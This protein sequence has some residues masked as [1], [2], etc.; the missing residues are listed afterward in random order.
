LNIND[1]K[2]SIL[3]ID[4][5]SNTNYIF[6]ITS[7]NSIKMCIYDDEMEL[8]ETHTGTNI[9]FSKDMLNKKYYLKFNYINVSS[10]GNVLININAHNHSY[11]TYRTYSTTQHKATCSCGTYILQYHIVNTEDM[12]RCVLCNGLVSSSGITPLSL[13]KNYITENGSYL[14]S[15][16]II[17]LVSIDYE[18]YLSGELNVYDLI[19]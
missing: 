10:F 14:L 2:D 4:S 13:I 1:G 17:V 9:Q 19:M 6:N 16:G 15:N 18:K 3:E 11:T 12:T 8:I 7:S 5:S